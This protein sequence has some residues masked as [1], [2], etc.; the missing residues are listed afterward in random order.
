MPTTNNVNNEFLNDV[1]VSTSIAGNTST[2]TIS[3][4]DN[5]NL[6]SSASVK[7]TSA[8]ALGGDC[9]IKFSNGVT[10]WS[11]GLDNSD[12]DQLVFSASSSLGTSNTAYPTSNGIWHYPMQSGFNAYKDADANDVTG[13]GAT[14]D[15]VS[16][17][18]RYDTGSDYNTATGVYTSPCDCKVL[19]STI[20]YLKN[21]TVVRYFRSTLKTS[22][23]NYMFTSFR[24]ADNGA[25][26]VGGSVIADMDIGDTAYNQI[27]ATGEAGNTD[28]FS[29]ASNRNQ[30]S[31]IVIT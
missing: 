13:N 21:P 20:C 19:F 24:P 26:S 6:S 14:Y 29:G 2:T 9:Y 28:D 7:I 22:N 1:Y 5:T 31:G 8:G 17:V 23:R 15:I 16:N 25:S 4:P 30:F 3:N 10:G 27:M 12:S 11:I 18:E